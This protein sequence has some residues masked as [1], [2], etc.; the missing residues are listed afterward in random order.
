MNYY[1]M[2]ETMQAVF[3]ATIPLSKAQNTHLRQVCVGVLLAG[4]SQLTRIARWL[5]QQ[6]QQDS[7]VQWLRRLLQAGF[8]TQEYVYYPF[9]KHVLTDYQAA[10]LH[11]VMDRTPLSD[12]QTDLLSLSLNFRKRAIPLVWRFMPQGRSDYGLQTHLIERC[13]ALLPLQRPVV[14]H[15]DNEFGSVGL[16]QYLRHLGWDFCVGQ[17]SKNY[18]RHWPRRNWQ[19]LSTLPVT[20][21]HGVYLSQIEL[22]KDYAY[23]PLN[24]F[25]FYQPRYSNGRCKH[26]I[27]YCA[28]S[29]PITPTLR[30]L[31][32]RRWGIECCFK[33][34]KSSGWN[35]QASDLTHAQRREGLFTVLSLAYLWATCLGRWLCKT[36]QRRAVDNKAQR[37]LSLFRLGWD[38]LVHRY[39]MDLPCPTLLTLYQ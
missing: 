16:M 14:L 13:Q 38:W 24:L 26:D 4:S 19:Q 32:H 37:H 7:R 3:E 23:G 36:A 2:E 9:V 12:K 34:F 29:L 28:T 17:S 27:T 1:A 25:A 21:R 30:R 6:T 39:N 31:G 11:L 33:D 22:T 5:N 35:V 15:G 18:Y 8:M 10:P 20:K